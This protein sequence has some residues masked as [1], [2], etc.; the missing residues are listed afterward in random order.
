MR[1][2]KFLSRAGVASRRAAERLMLDGRVRVNGAPATELGTKVDPERDRVE[3]DGTVVHLARP[4]WVALN[5]P[6]LVLST[7]DDPQGRRTIY[8]LLPAEFDGLFYVGRLDYDSEGLLLLTNQGDIANR[9]MHPSYEVDREYEVHTADPLT[10]AAQR[11]LRRGVE[12][13]DGPARVATLVRMRAHPRTGRA[14][15]R[16]VIREGRN[17][18]VRRMF[19]AAGHPVER[20]VRIRYGPIRLGELERGAWRRLDASERQALERIGS[21]RGA[22]HGNQRS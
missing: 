21:N 3:V 19:A 1:L 11:Q 9:M 18:E 17:R 22:G 14:R 15:A 7:R 10:E 13:E 2:Q 16:V 8:D 5:K 20:L 6:A 4:E 12:L